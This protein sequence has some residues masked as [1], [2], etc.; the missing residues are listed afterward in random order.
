MGLLPR[1]LV[2]GVES[3]QLLGDT[4]VEKQ[5]PAVTLDHSATSPSMSASRS[6]GSAAAACMACTSPCGKLHKC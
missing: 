1:P 5:I 2:G 4:L 6:T 3:L